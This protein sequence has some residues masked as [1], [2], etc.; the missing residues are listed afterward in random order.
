MPGWC[1]PELE[2]VIAACLAKDI[3]DRP[4]DA[5]ALAARLHAIPIPAERAWTADHAAWWRAYQPATPPAGVSA[6]EVQV[7][8]PGRTDQRPVAATS[9]AAIAKTI[10]ATSEAAIAQTVAASPQ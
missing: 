9:E 2:A 3:A 7:I 6:S 10:A 1:P 4:R 8:M 5:R